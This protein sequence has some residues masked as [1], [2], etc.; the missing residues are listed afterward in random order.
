[1]SQFGGVHMSFIESFR[2]DICHQVLRGEIGPKEAALKIGKSYRQTLRII[3]KVQAKGL[4]GIKHGNFGK[5]PVNKSDPLLKAKVIGLYKSEYFDFN[6]THFLEQLQMAHGISVPHET[7]RLWAHE[8]NHV[9]RKHRKRKKAHPLRT[10]MTRPGTMVQMDGSHHDWFGN[11]IKP[12][13]IGCIDDATSKCVYAEFF[14]AEDRISVMT[15]MQ[16][17]FEKFGV[18][19]LVYVDQAAAHGKA[20][21]FRQFSGWQ[22]HI[23][24]LE[25]TLFQFGSRMI[26]A[27]SPQGKGRVERMWNTFQDRL[28]PEIRRQNI[29]NIPKA[30]AYLWNHFIPDH[31]KRFEVIPTDPNPAWRILDDTT[32]RTL[33]SAFYMQEFRKI[34]SGE[35][36]SMGGKRYLIDHDFENS[37]EG[38]QI[39]IRTML[40]GQQKLFYADREVRL[41]DQKIIL[42]AA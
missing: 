26:F 32:K 1:M 36:I 3:A 13:L 16:R 7:F 5:T 15:V 29:K 8:E 35:L 34:L 31:Y 42:R 24:D 10:R 23:T 39:E 17:V 28:V 18:P 9:K 25:R 30:N 6:M 38:M 33:D 4:V 14:P 21:I 41:N 19:G 11:N 40:N 27:T 12:V 37:L 2:V 22:D 20:G